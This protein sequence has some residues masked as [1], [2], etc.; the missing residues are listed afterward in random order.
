MGEPEKDDKKNN[1]VSSSEYTSDSEYSKES[2]VFELSSDSDEDKE[3]E[4]QTQKEKVESG[5]IDNGI[6][7]HL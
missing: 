2:S 3:Q 4:K 6:M 7:V 1:N 5:T